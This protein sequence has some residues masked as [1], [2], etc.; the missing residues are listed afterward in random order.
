MSWAA[1]MCLTPEP[2]W[3][4]SARPTRPVD[5][6]VRGPQSGTPSRRLL[7]RSNVYVSKWFIEYATI[8]TIPTWITFLLTKYLISNFCNWFY[9]HIYCKNYMFITFIWEYINIIKQFTSYQCKYILCIVHS[10]KIGVVFIKHLW[11]WVKC[12]S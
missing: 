10:N 6:V 8:S 4:S 2:T 3:G 11:F 5:D 9:M 7:Y 1:L 12:Y